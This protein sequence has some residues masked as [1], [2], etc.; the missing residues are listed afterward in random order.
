MPPTFLI[1][2]A[3]VRRNCEILAGIKRRSGCRIVHALKAF[4][5]PAAF[6]LLRQYLDG[7]CA[8]GPWEAR[9]AAEFFGGHILTCSPAYT[10]ADLDTLLPLTHHLDFNSPGQW[11][12]FRTRVTS[13]PRFRSGELR[14]GLRVPM[15]EG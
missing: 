1:D 7:C 8:S 4:A 11:E 10:H 12:R 6:P 5:L 3:R 9:L 13:H 15:Q 14:C 2:L